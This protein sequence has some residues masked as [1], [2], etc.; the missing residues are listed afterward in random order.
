[1][2]PGWERDVK[3]HE[4]W[5]LR[6]SGGGGGIGGIGG[7][8]GVDGSGGSSGV[9]DSG[10]SILYRSGGGGGSVVYSRTVQE[11]DCTVQ[12]VGC[13]GVVDALV[14]VGFLWW[15][16]WRQWNWWWGVL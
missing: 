12:E 5:D 1:M 2:E 10:A 7:S 4:G 9:G 15:R 11:V 6:S 13:T 3:L 16:W 8:S 14:L